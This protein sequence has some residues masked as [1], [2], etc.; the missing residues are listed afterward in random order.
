VRGSVRDRMRLTGLLEHIGEEH[1]YMTVDAAVRA[2]EA[3]PVQEFKPPEIT[4]DPA[5]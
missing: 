5:A 3:R 1:I 2:F 4:T